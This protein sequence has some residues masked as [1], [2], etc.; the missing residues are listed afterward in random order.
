M[1]Q[2]WSSGITSFQCLWGGMMYHKEIWN[3]FECVITFLWLIF[4]PQQCVLL[5]IILMKLMWYLIIMIGPL[6]NATVQYINK[7]IR[8]EQQKR[9][10]ISLHFCL[11]HISAFCV[12]NV[13]VWLFLWNILIP[14]LQLQ[15][16]ISNH[17]ET[18]PE[19]AKKGNESSKYRQWPLQTP[20]MIN[21]KGFLF[22]ICQSF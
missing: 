18:C 15:Q 8:L 20:N 10:W 11:L 1:R 2:S 22:L 4:T 14:T 9:G 13:V 5:N 12:K 19:G 3:K 21:V 6:T 17:S 7:R 16:A